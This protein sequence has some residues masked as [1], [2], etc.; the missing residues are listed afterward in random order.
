M[1][2]KDGQNKTFHIRDVDLDSHGSALWNTS[3]IRI[4]TSIWRMQIRIQ[5]LKIVENA[6]KQCHKNEREKN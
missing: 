1:I 6:P 3:W 5:E 2:S 4:C